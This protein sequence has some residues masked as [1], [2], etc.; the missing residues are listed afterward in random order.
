MNPRAS[1]IAIKAIAAEYIRRVTL[2]FL[3]GGLI[4]III[5]LCITFYLAQSVSMWWLIMLLPFSLPIIFLLVALFI[6]KQLTTY[7]APGLS[8]DQRK[9]VADFVDKLQRT[10]ENLRTPPFI[11]AWHTIRTARSGQQ[12]YLWHIVNDS[13]TLKDDFARVSR[14]F[15]A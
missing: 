14:H 5:L 10:S 2:P 1:A 6:V 7:L 13:T 12:N 11:I 4:M 15:D 8:K 9:S 3:I